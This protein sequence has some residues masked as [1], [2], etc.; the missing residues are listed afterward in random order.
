MV[1]KPEQPLV[2]LPVHSPEQVPPQG[3][4][5]YLTKLPEGSFL[6]SV[7]LIRNSILS[8]SSSEKN[9]I[10]LLYVITKSI[11]KLS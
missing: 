5:E 9:M 2:Q 8:I 10:S 6:T 7:D 1:K 3:Q 11:R 4:G